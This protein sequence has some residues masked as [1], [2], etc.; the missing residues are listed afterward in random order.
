MIVG[1]TT[2]VWQSLKRGALILI[3]FGVA[4]SLFFWL[5][6]RLL[7]YLRIFP[8]NYRLLAAIL[9]PFLVFIIGYLSET[10]V[11]WLSARIQMAMTFLL[12]RRFEGA[13]EGGELKPS[14]WLL[15]EVAFAEDGHFGDEEEPDVQT[16]GVVTAEVPGDPEQIWVLFVY[17]PTGTGRFMLIR[18][19]SRR[20]RLTGRAVADYAVTTASLGRNM[21]SV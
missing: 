1:R 6:G 7:G 21:H 2:K 10:V 9:T 11:P 17:P 13:R 4:S 20:V 19:D 15:K 3:G 16:F 18:K 8:E 5:W 14:S 12:I